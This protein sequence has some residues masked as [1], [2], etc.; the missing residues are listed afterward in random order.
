LTFRDALEWCG[1][2]AARRPSDAHPA[3]FSSQRKVGIGGTG[4]CNGPVCRG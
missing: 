1:P 2:L 4:I 3:T